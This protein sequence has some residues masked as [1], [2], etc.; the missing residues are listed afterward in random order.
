MVHSEMV[1]LEKWST[2]N[3]KIRL[4]WYKFNFAP[5]EGYK[6]KKWILIESEVDQNARIFFENGPK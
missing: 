6:T 5:L 2:Q 4:E 3:Q 1:P